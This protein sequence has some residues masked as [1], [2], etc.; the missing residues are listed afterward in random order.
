M[1]ASG[2]LPSCLAVVGLAACTAPAPAPGAPGDEALVQ[3]QGGPRARDYFFPPSAGWRV[4]HA[5]QALD[6]MPAGVPGFDASGSVLTEVIG[7]AADRATLRITTTAPDEEGRMTT[8]VA[9]ASL[10]VMPDGTVVREDEGGQERLPSAML[11]AAGVE[12]LPA[13]GSL[14]ALRAW[15]VGE[16]L[17]TTRAGSY[18]TL[19]L[20]EGSAPMPPTHLWV[21]A[22]VGIVRQ[23]WLGTMSVPVG[24]RGMAVGTSSF[25]LELVEAAI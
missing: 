12:L 6:E 2:I 22:G 17:L 24:D 13:S 1:R 4:R 21:A 23:S 16:E 19:H 15:R 11:T 5:F 25:T 7:W 3:Q 10:A 14:G 18:P 8:G 9:T 20:L